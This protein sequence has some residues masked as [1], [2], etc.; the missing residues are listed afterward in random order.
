MASFYTPTVST[1]FPT[2]FCLNRPR[3]PQQP[4]SPHRD[5]KPSSCN[6]H[7]THKVPETCTAIEIS[8]SQLA[9]SATDGSPSTHT[10]VQESSTKDAQ[11]FGAVQC[12]STV[13]YWKHWYLIENDAS[14]PYAREWEHP[15]RYDGLAA[16]AKQG[17]AAGKLWIDGSHARTEDGQPFT[18]SG[19]CLDSHYF[20]TAAHYLVD[21]SPE[22][23]AKSIVKMRD[24]NVYGI[25]ISVNQTSEQ[26]SK[27]TSDP[28]LRFAYLVCE[29]RERDVAIF[30]IQDGE[31]SWKHAISPNQLAPA[32]QHIWN[33][34]FSVGYAAHCHG[35]KQETDYERSWDGMQAALQADPD[36]SLRNKF[37]DLV[38]KTG[39]PD[40]LEI[41]W[42]NRRA[43]A[44]GYILATEA[45][46]GILKQDDGGWGHH[47]VPGWYGL[48]GSMM[49][50]LVGPR[51]EVQIIGLFKGGQCNEFPN[52][53]V[54]FTPEIID[55]IY[56]VIG[57]T[58]PD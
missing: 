58:G 57:Y 30:R 46:P 41:F 55:W 32:A 9:P 45:T 7:E 37:H 54:A 53:L 23:R 36:S 13:D 56:S 31:N 50:V 39:K 29:D 28:S 42:P 1:L 43:I 11:Y 25:T 6:I 47:N 21:A 10:P 22:E 26:M 8:L 12:N 5:T 24:P 15:S 33:Y 38:A 4:P 40:F 20:I 16:A 48:S 35:Q 3:K 17:L 2:D 34:T 51:L 44:F 27:Y 18:M 19:V 14:V 52:R 49:G